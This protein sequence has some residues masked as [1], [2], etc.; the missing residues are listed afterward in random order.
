[1]ISA[2][3]FGIMKI[4]LLHN[5]YQR[6]GGEDVAVARER[7]LLEAHGHD[8]RLYA[9]SNETVK[10][11]WDI[12][13]TAWLTIYSRSARRDV[14]DEIDRFRPDVVHVHNFFPLLTPSVYDACRAAAIPVIQSLH[15]YRL[16]CVN[17][18]FLRNGRVCEL[19]LGKAFPWPGVLHNCWR[20]RAASGTVAAMVA[21]HRILRTWT[22]KVDVYLTLTDFARGKFIQAGLPAEK[23][24]VKPNFVH[25]DPGVGSSRGDYALFAGRLVPEKG[26]ATLLAAMER[27]RGRI[28][29]KIVGAGPLTDQVR[30]SARRIPNLEWVGQQS[31]EGVLA[32]MKDARVLIVPSIYYEGF[33]TV[34]AEAYS[35]GLPVVATQL[36]SLPSLIADGHSGLLFR[37]GDPDDLAAK[38]TWLW[39]HPRERDEMRRGARHEFEI[40]YSGAR[41]YE[42]L[43][44]VYAR[45]MAHLR[46]N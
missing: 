24:V 4:L 28:P 7:E 6:Q 22:E 44:A 13:K 35:V 34:I 1:M 26:I 29:L 27:L 10:D 40:K 25:P 36:G 38:L 20:N 41:N 11:K 21:V 18:Q 43:M 46:K 23:I 31:P 37:R 15:N 9:V 5:Y 16:I 14:A 33:A 30:A 12:V 8:V 42:M 2:D 39:A 32:L 3:P 19:C 17:T 45:A